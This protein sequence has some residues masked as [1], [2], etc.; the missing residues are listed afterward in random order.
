MTL[1][2]LLES[3]GGIHLTAYLVNRGDLMDLKTQLRTTIKEAHDWLNTVLSKDERRKFLEPL[4]SVSKDIRIF[5]QMKGNIGIFRNEHSFRILT[6]PIHIEQSCQVATSFHIKPLLR[7]LQN[8]QDFL[9]LGLDRQ[10]AQLYLGNQESFKLID[11]MLFPEIFRA[12]RTA[13]L[14]FSAAREM[15][16]K[17]AETFSWVNDWILELTRSSKPKLFVAGES[18]LVQAL[19]RSL[20]YKNTIKNPLSSTY[21]DE[22]VMEYSQKIR[23]ILKVES[24]SILEKALIEFQFAEEGKR[25]KKNLFQISKAVVEGRVRKLIV[26]DDISIFGKIDEKSG[27]IAIHPCD[28]DHEDDCVLDDLAQM[29]LIQGGEVV[30]AKKNEIPNGR[31]IL[32]ILNDDQLSADKK[33]EFQYKILE[34]RF[35]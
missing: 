18:K 4:D 35:G 25:T 12:E 11:S 10:S 29:V 21:S 23:N 5:K 9:F 27:G 34:E 13:T 8:D 32:A 31:S 3:K 33:E 22:Y 28:L 7:W 20:N 1:K 30:L 2:P 26:T 6:I 17:E 19:H 14:D 16:M 24:Q 15:R